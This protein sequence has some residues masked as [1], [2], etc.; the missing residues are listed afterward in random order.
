MNDYVSF[1][2]K[3]DNSEEPIYA[4][5]V[6]GIGVLIYICEALCYLMFFLILYE[7]NNGSSILPAAVKKSRNHSNAHTMMGQFSL[8]ITETFFMLILFLIFV[9]GLNKNFPNAK[10][11]GLIYKEVEFGF[12]SV[13]QCLMIPDSRKLFLKFIKQQ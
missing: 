4:A 6:I 7:H 1:S 9:L 12:V 2:L 8:F 10:D 5:I 11:V 3:T 13:V